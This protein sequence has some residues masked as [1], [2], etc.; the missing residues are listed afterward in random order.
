MPRD[1]R[2]GLGIGAMLGFAVGDY[3]CNLYWQSVSIFLLFFY[4]DVVGLP[5]ATA[6]MIYMIASVFD[7]AIDPLMGVLADGTRTRWGRYRP[8]LLFGAVPL[9]A[10]FVLLYYQPPL[11]GAGLIAFV[12]VAHL[13]F[14]VTYTAVSI[15]YTSLTARITRSSDE[16]S[17]LAAFR[18]MFATV[19]GLTVAMLTR[20]L[21]S[22]SVGPLGG[23]AVAALAFAAIA[24]IILPAVF[25]AVRE[26]PLEAEPPRLHLCQHWQAVRGNGAFW[27]LMI[28][29]TM[30]VVCSTALGK[31]V[32]YYFK[33]Y[34]HDEAGA[35][36]ALS[37]NAAAGLL[38]IPAWVVASRRVG[39]R[40]AWFIATAWGLAGLVFFAVTDI[41]SSAL[42]TGFLVY[43]Q[44]AVLGIAMTFW[45]MLPDTVEYGEWRSGLRTESVIFGLGQFFLKVALGLGAGLFGWALGHVGYVPNQPQTPETLAGLKTIMIVLPAFGV[46]ASGLVM[47]FY[48]MRRDDHADIVRDIAQKTAAATAA[49]PQVV[50]S[51]ELVR[52]PSLPQRIGERAYQ[53]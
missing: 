51:P 2:G 15:P 20:P 23:F 21:A 38:I 19:A 8:Y 53:R 26:P 33:Y 17:T 44:V 1:R 3:A 32:L 46:A 35:Q 12:L 5:A 50:N 45:S 11:Q 42:M 14:R 27:V 31:S 49:S 25:V 48:P 52:E 34:L 30:A 41:R 24:T 7:G 37:V 43:M 13:S 4:T 36:I 10:S 28:G 40:G 39:K 9:G 22:M 16:R 47:W 29:I 18:I 6:G